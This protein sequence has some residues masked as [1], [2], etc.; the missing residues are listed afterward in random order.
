MKKFYVTLVEAY[1]KFGLKTRKNH[2]L[3][4]DVTLMQAF[5]LS[6]EIWAMYTKVL[7]NMIFAPDS[8]PKFSSYTF[9]ETP[10]SST[11]FFLL[12]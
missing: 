9:S 11:T 3:E 7:S 10:S 1:L 6:I 4:L 8:S 2:F 12:D 5:T